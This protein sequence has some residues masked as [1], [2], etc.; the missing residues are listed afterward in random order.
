VTTK[1]LGDSGAI[2]FRGELFNVL[3]HPNF[4][5]PNSAVFAGSLTNVTETPIAT[6]GQITSTV[7]TSRQVELSLKLVW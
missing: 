1:L 4:S 5:E 2:E 3:N 6:A 7:G